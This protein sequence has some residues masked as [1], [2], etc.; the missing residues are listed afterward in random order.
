MTNT[1]L[2]KEEHPNDDNSHL[3]DDC[4]S[5]SS[6]KLCDACAAS[7]EHGAC[8]DEANAVCEEARLRLELLYGDEDVISMVVDALGFVEWAREQLS[9]N[10]KCDGETHTKDALP[11][12]HV[13]RLLTT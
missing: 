10:E 9:R 6:A 13:E 1:W 5:G 8:K 3:F 7:V 4:A 11:S 2:E 12:H